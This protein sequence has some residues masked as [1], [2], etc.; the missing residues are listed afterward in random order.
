M[1]WVYILKNEETNRYYIGSTSNLSRRLKQHALG[2]TRT[3]RIL[4]TDKLVYQEKFS[5]V[6]EAK[7]RE[8]KLKSY[9]SKK[10]IEWL[11]SNKSK[12]R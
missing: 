7:L 8:K 9:K 2:S 10:Y 5:N 1:C 4:K 12:A 6:A 11:I 3:T